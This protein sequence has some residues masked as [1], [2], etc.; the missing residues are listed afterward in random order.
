MKN[1]IAREFDVFQHV[2]KICCSIPKKNYY[3]YL[4]GVNSW[5]DK[6]I[7]KQKYKLIIKYIHPDIGKH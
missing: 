7:I 6:E 2:L 5:D 4:L 3:Y 1:I